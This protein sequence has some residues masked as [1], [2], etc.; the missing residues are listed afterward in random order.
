MPPYDSCTCNHASPSVPAQSLSCCLALAEM[1]RGVQSDVQPLSIGPVLTGLILVPMP[2]LASLI[3]CP[4]VAPQRRRSHCT[5]VR[6][7]RGRPRLEF[8]EGREHHPPAGLPAGASRSAPPPLLQGPCFA[9]GPRSKNDTSSAQHRKRLRRWRVLQSQ[10][11]CSIA[12]L[13]HAAHGLYGEWRRNAK[14]RTRRSLQ[15]AQHWSAE[16]H[17]S[18]LRAVEPTAQ[19]I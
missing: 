10:S 13:W 17:L 16:Q 8:A 5:Q 15:R 11:R 12:A 6:C 7:K 3:A 2:P 19:R 9:H 14:G 4:E 18:A 1:A